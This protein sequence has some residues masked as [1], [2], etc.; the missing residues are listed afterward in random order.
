MV[1]MEGNTRFSESDFSENYTF[2]F[3][4]NTYL[5]RI[6]GFINWTHDEM[7]SGTTIRIDQNYFAGVYAIHSYK[8]SYEDLVGAIF[9]DN[10]EFKRQGVSY[11]GGLHNIFSVSVCDF[12]CDVGWVHGDFLWDGWRKIDI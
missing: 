10:L 3:S 9:I 4:A 7:V 1:E 2:D 5:S 8:L 6:N 12:H 11:F